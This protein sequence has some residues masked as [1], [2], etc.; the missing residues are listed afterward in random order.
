MRP[1]IDCGTGFA[2]AAVQYPAI[3]LA[4]AVAGIDGPAIDVEKGA[5]TEFIA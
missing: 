5:L 1:S 4:V 3:E 2:Q